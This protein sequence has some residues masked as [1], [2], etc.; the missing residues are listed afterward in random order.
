M[1]VTPGSINVVTFPITFNTSGN[2]VTDG[3][4]YGL[5][6]GLCKVSSCAGGEYTYFTASYKNPDKLLRWTPPDPGVESETGIDIPAIS[7]TP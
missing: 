7:G 1:T 2:V 4:T 3:H 6:I 5:H